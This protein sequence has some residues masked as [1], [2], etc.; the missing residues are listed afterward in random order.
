[1][2]EPPEKN[3]EDLWKKVVVFCRGMMDTD[4]DRSKMERYFPQFVSHRFVGN[5]YHIGV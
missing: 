2:D 3:G 1:M 4:A 5:E